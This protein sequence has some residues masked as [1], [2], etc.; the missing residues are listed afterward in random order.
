MGTSLGQLTHERSGQP[1]TANLAGQ[2]HES[3]MV[4][5]EFGQSDFRQVSVA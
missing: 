4:E 1:P 5:T 3:N 2:N